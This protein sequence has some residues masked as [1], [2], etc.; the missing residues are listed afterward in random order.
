MSAQEN[1][2]ER[3]RAAQMTEARPRE[4]ELR[5][6]PSLS[7]CRLTDAGA[8]NVFLVDRDGYRRRIPNYTTYSRLFRDWS[9][10][11]ETPDIEGLAKRPDFAAG[12]ILVRGDASGPIYLLDHGRRR[13]ITDGAVMNKYWFN[14]NR[15]FVIRQVLI[16]HMP[17]GEEWE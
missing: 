10:L 1:D 13:V 7:G 17:L 2:S 3:M 5:P 16:D 12:T 14:W 6:R 4:V 11:V 15:V 8:A 9:G